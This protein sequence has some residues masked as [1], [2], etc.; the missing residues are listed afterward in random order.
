MMHVGVATHESSSALEQAVC[1]SLLVHAK[2]SWDFGR[3]P[4]EHFTSQQ[5]RA[6]SL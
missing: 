6:G 4:M 1:G 5:I 3:P 2:A